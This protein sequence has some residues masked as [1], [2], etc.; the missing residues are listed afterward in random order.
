MAD[1]HD[2]SGE[3]GKKHAHKRGGHGHGHGGGG[4][5][6]GHEGAPEW[7]ISFADM[8]MLMMGFFVIL[9]ALNVQ[10]KGGNAGGGGDQA[11]GVA[12]E[13][14]LI[15]FA[16]AVRRAFNNEVDINSTDPR[17]APL[18]Q[19]LLEHQRQGAGES[20]DDGTR[21]K[22][23]NV[24]SVRPSDFYGKG[25]MIAFGHRATMLD[26][27]AARVIQDFSEKH[28]GRNS[29]IEI[30]GHASSA[31]AFRRP[32]EAMTLAYDRAMNSARAL[33]AAGIDWWRL[34]VTACGDHERVEAFPGDAEADARNARVEIL[35][36]D[37]VA[38][39]RAP[40]RPGDAGP[41]REGEGTDAGS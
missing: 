19:R 36:T 2:Q 32:E 28:R 23:R 6:E 41:A 31:E 38:P 8:V 12:N 7:L 25:T 15:D 40:T 22:D 37:E 4:H 30:R 1:A 11:E 27:E 18:V 35:V 21:G 24:R 20:R 26:A 5:E 13:P 34:R 39:P 16:I 17:D 14:D 29:V 3:H 10:P 9:F 33:A